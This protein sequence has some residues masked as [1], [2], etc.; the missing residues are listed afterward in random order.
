MNKETPRKHSHP[1]P[2]GNNAHAFIELRAKQ[3][4]LKDA[5]IARRLGLSRERVRQFKEK[6]YLARVIPE[7]PK[8]PCKQCGQLLDT[9]HQIFCS[10]H[11][12]S[13]SHRTELECTSC[14]RLFY[15]MKSAIRRDEKRS[16]NK[17]LFCSKQCFGKWAG[18]YHGFG[19]FPYPHKKAQNYGRARMRE[20]EQARH[21]PI[22]P[23][24]GV[25]S[26][27]PIE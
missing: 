5:E 23:P 18:K 25:N 6:F 8:H 26:V 13:L 20:I 12:L 21:S 2:I 9:R 3:P 19:S 17:L 11:C 27:A 14:G 22:L 7:K 24:I 4:H 10:R 15:R 16:P 1:Q